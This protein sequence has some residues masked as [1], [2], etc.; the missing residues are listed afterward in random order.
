MS[1]EAWINSFDR[2]P[3]NDEPVIVVISGRYS[4]YGMP[5]DIKD[6]VITGSFR[7][8]RGWSVKSKGIDYFEVMW[9]M[10]LPKI[11]EM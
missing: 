2:L 4:P 9:W 7:Y 6:L 8:K 11:P 3:A 1:N 5:E 10:P